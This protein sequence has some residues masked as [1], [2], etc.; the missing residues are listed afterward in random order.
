GLF[1]IKSLMDDVQYYRS[2][3]RNTL[4]MRKVRT[5]Q[6]HRSS[7]EADI[8]SLDEA[9][10]QLES[11]QQTISGMARELCLRSESLSAIFR[12]CAELGRTSDLEGFANRLLN[13]LLHLTSADWFVLRQLPTGESRLF[14]FVASAPE[15]RSAPLP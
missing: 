11:C 14:T 7:A 9:R 6:Q 12:C 13:D 5:H 10:H 8:T 2:A 4:V 1:I 3:E 15:L